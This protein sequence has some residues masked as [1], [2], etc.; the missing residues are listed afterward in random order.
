MQIKAGVEQ[1]PRACD[2]TRIIYIQ[3]RT[4]ALFI[5]SWV[6]MKNLFC[7]RSREGLRVFVLGPEEESQVNVLYRKCCPTF[8]SIPPRAVI[9]IYK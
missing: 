2:E 7:E 6:V 9:L 8:I 1:R 4:G 5:R 3:Q